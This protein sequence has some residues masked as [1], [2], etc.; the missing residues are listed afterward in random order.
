MSVR[1]L[2]VRFSDDGTI[3]IDW[4]D[5]TMMK[6]EGGTIHSTYFTTAALETD[7]QVAYWAKEMFQDIDELLGHAR[8]LVE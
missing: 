3:T 8:K 7:E 5:E 4:S 6:R 1:L 2:S